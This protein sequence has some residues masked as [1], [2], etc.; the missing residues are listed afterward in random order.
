VINNLQQSRVPLFTTPF[1]P[2][3][4]TFIA[5]LARA[6]PHGSPT[7]HTWLL[8]TLFT[9]PVGHAPQSTAHVSIVVVAILCNQSYSDVSAGDVL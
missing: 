9:Q 2:F 3:I 6:A 5:C 8:A 7:V 1:S 4:N